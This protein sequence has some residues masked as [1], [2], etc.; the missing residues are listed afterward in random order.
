[1]THEEL[2]IRLAAS[3]EA[4]RRTRIAFCTSL[5]IALGILFACYN[6]YF[7]WY[8]AFTFKDLPPD[9]TTRNLVF[10]GILTEW[11]KSRQFTLPFLGVHVAASDASLLGSITLLITSLWLAFAQRRENHSIAMLLND[12]W[13][14]PKEIQRSAFYGIASYMVFSSVSDDDRPIHTLPA[15][16]PGDSISLLRSLAKSLMYFPLCVLVLFIG[17]RI[18]KSGHI[19]VWSEHIITFVVILIMV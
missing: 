10:S 16:P 19:F 3:N 17:I 4:Q 12:T 15:P 6:A 14:A 11:I 13:T 7:S 5:I 18:I 1:M 8:K 9:H 2:S